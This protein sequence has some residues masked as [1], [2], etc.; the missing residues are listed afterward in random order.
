[1]HDF[2]IVG[3]DKIISD[4]GMVGNTRKAYPFFLQVASTAQ[5]DYC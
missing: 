4:S 1:M 3:M 5:Q 2:Y